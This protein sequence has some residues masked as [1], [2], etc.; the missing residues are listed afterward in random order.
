MKN[1]NLLSEKSAKQRKVLLIICLLD[2]CV[3]KIGFVPTRINA[4]GITVNEINQTSII[5]L[6][7]FIS[8]F[9]LISFSFYSFIDFILYRY[10]YFNYKLSNLAEKRDE[11]GRMIA[12]NEN[13][14]KLLTE[15]EH[16]DELEEIEKLEELTKEHR[17]LIILQEKIKRKLKTY[18]RYFYQQ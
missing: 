13:F 10:E 9:S 6:L 14:E 5:S 17:P 12:K 7:F 8:I 15:V 11:I 2:F 3:I 16:I 18:D 4:F 1:Q